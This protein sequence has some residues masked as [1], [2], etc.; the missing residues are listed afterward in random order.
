MSYDNPPVSIE[1]LVAYA[2]GQLQPARELQ[3]A[4]YLLEHPEAVKQVEA[5][6]QQSRE[7][8]RLFDPTLSAPLPQQLLRPEELPAP[9]RH[10]LAPRWGWGIA[11]AVAWI[12][13]GVTL[14]WL[15]KG[16]Q[17]VAV[18]PRIAQQTPVLLRQASVAHAVYAPEVLHPVEV[19]AKEEVHLAKWLSKRLNKDIRIPSFTEQGFSLVGGRLLPAEPGT[20][21]AQF[22][23]E[24]KNMQ[25]FTLYVR[26]M[27][28]KENDTSF[29]YGENKGISV[30]YWIDRDWGYALSGKLDRETL[31]ALADAAYRQFNL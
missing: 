9:L 5:Y 23:Y 30:F 12:G 4:N 31:L 22:M 7:L 15:L 29:R 26:A 6:R 20:A 19:T 25:R 3:V 17:T 10:K 28:K 21:A 8:H 14:G 2:D 24:N 13:L 1:D 16:Q 11:A 18:D 27:E